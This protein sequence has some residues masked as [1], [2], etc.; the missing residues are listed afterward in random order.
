M[1]G[2]ASVHFRRAV[3]LE[4]C[5][6]KECREEAIKDLEFSRDI[7]RQLGNDSVEEG[8]QDLDLLVQEITAKVE[9]TNFLIHYVDRRSQRVHEPA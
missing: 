7:L 1:R 3:S 2:L 5:G 6:T 4:L 8:K 9:T